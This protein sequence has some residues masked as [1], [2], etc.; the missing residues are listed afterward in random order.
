[1]EISLVRRVAAYCI[2]A[3]SISIWS[4]S[5]QKKE[6]PPA[7]SVASHPEDHLVGTWKL[8]TDKTP[9]FERYRSN[10]IPVYEWI[11]ISRVGDRFTLVF[12]HDS[13]KP[14][15]ADRVFIGDMKTPAVRVD[16][17]SGKLA[18]SSTYLRRVDP[19]SF[20]QGSDVSENEYKVSPDGKTMKV[21]QMPFIDNGAERR[22]V[23]D[24]VANAD[25]TLI[26]PF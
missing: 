1:M 26:P 18:V 19:D 12:S 11:T 22:L 6:S 21:H 3:T 2:L 24:K 17:V 15:E 4:A 20:V 7:S 8:N 5:C 13:N 23:Y 14:S 9:V 25:V 16:A 10:P